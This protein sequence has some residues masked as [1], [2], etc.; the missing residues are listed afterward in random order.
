MEEPLPKD[1]YL[2]LPD[3]AGWGVELNRDGLNLR[4]PCLVDWSSE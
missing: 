4:R 3:K 1:G 2:T